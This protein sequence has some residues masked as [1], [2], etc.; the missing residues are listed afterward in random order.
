MIQKTENQG[1][2]SLTDADKIVSGGRGLKEA[3]NF[4]LLHQLAES[5]GGVV[6]ASRAVVDAGWVPHS[7]QVGQTG[8]SV[9]PK[10]YV[11]CGIS[12]AIQHLVGIQNA[13][14]VVAI[15]SDP[16][17]NI[18]KQSNYGLVGDLFQIIP[19]IIEELKAISLDP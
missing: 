18:F 11:A 4:K 16:S 17:A 9:S 10:L 3:K 7:M 2:K 8:S 6:G 14:I 1:Q 12:G 13:G 15:N 19:A 5:L